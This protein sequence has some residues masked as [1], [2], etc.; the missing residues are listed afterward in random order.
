MSLAMEPFKKDQFEGA[1][2][3]VYAATTTK[4]SGQ[5]ICPPAIIEPGSQMSQDV[6]LGNQLMVLTRAIIAEKTKKES[7]NK[8][9]P[10]DDSLQ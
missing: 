1:V 8:G 3:T 10:F 5:Y 7:V 2:S 6:V 9:C 4:K